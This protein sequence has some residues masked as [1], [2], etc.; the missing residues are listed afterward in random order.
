MLRRKETPARLNFVLYLS[1]I[2]CQFHRYYCPASSTYILLYIARP[3][4]LF[5]DMLLAE[6]LNHMVRRE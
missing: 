2:C 5:M 4:L 3:L 1:C 6:Y